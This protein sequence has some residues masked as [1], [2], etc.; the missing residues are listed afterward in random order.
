MSKCDQAAAHS[1]TE[2]SVG[3]CTSLG[4]HLVLKSYYETQCLKIHICADFFAQ[5][6][7]KCFFKAEGAKQKM[8]QTSDTTV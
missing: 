5:F 3:F 8:V 1:A 6:Y 4:E 7:F 2:P